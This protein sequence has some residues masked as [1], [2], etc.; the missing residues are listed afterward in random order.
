M[1][2]VSRNKRKKR[3]AEEVENRLSSS[4]FKYHLLCI[5]EMCR[6]NV[7][8]ENKIPT[9][10]LLFVCLFVCL[11]VCLFGYI[12]LK[13]QTSDDLIAWIMAFSSLARILGER[14]SFPACAF[15]LKWGS[16]RTHRFH[17]L[18]QDQS[19]VAQRAKTTV[20]ECSLTSCMWA[21][22]SARFLH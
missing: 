19:T 9:D 3:K 5:L 17:F 21:R 8:L 4:S 6:Y 11:S 2:I 14:N 7:D 15:F 12:G 13:R 22:F 18:R 10:L 1:F 20:A 16:S